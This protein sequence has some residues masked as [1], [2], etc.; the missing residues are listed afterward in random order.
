MVPRARV[1]HEWRG[2]VLLDNVPHLAPQHNRD[3]ALPG[4]LRFLHRVHTVLPLDVGITAEGEHHAVR[5]WEVRPQPG[6]GVDEGQLPFPTKRDPHRDVLIPRPLRVECCRVVVKGLPVLVISVP[7]EPRPYRLEFDIVVVGR[8]LQNLLKRRAVLWP[9]A[10]EVA[11]LVP[12]NPVRLVLAISLR[13]SHLLHEL[14]VDAP[15]VFV[16]EK[17]RDHYH[18]V[19]FQWLAVGRSI[20]P[21]AHPHLWPH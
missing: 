2:T 4:I 21:D 6:V 11:S 19:V 18:V 3:P 17:L 1:H 14:V 13:L 20:R 8:F 10:D 7:V 16:T 5:L 9:F 15:V 12:R